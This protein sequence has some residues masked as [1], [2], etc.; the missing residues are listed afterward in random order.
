MT[1]VA[2]SAGPARTD[3]KGGQLG[4]I[5]PEVWSALLHDAKARPGARGGVPAWARAVPLLAGGDVIEPA[6]AGAA[7]RAGCHQAPDVALPDRLAG[8]ESGAPASPTE[9]PQVRGTV[10]GPHRRNG[11]LRYTCYAC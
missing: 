9:T 10:G 6:R 2:M 3:G 1:V 4:R 7:G 8:A 11:T 5:P